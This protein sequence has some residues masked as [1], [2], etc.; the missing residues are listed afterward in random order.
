LVLKDAMTKRW[1]IR[2]HDQSLIATLQSQ[3]RVSAVVA[4]MLAAR[5]LHSP[6]QIQV[7]LNPKLNDLREPDQLPGAAEAAERLIQAVRARRPI[8][9][10]GDYD[11]DGITG[12][13]LLYE[14]LSLAGAQ[15][16]YYVPHRIDEGYGLHDEALETL[17]ARGASLVVTVDCGIGSVAQAETARR[18]GLELIITDHHTPGARLPAAAAIVHPSLP[19]TAYPFAGLS[20]AGV[21]FKLAWAVCQRAAE[22]KKVSPPMRAFLI[23]A[24][25][26]AAIGT[27]ADVVPLLDENRIIVC[28]GLK[29]LTVEPG[30]G[31]G[32]LMKLTKLDAKRNL[33]AEDIGFTL[34]PRLNAAGRLGQAQLA[35][36]LLTTSSPERATALAEYLHELNSSRE[37]LERSVHLASNKQAQEMFDPAGDAALVLAG[38]DWH[39]GVIGIVAGRLAEKYHRPVVLISLDALGVKPGIGSVRGVAGFDVQQALARC[40]ELLVSHGGH[41]AAAGLKIEESQIEL[42]RE[43][44]CRHA[45]D[46]STDGGRL[47]DL[48]IDAEAPLSAL[49]LQAIEQLEQLGPFGHGNLRPLLCGM[50]LK[51]VAPPRKIGGGGRHLSLRLAQHGAQIRGVA[52]GM[53]DQAEELERAG[54]SLNVAFRPVVNR[55]QGR[56]AVELHV[57]DWQPASAATDR[58]EA[59]MTVIAGAQAKTVSDAG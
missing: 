52:F 55:F 24:L 30:L 29:S 37:S 20:G 19:G 11:A 45:E 42:F 57:V 27:V 28:H 18:L 4:Q 7:F 40:S 46:S 16:S 51:L 56:A 2:P 8:V 50:G 5:G 23:K 22:A 36:E 25:G 35:V 12:T 6:A 21:A 58:P 34:G 41:A 47:S 26:L 15:V 3:S 44:F 49:T 38:R 31:L 43:Q 32:C 54:G 33:E 17:A 48:W 59:C 10:Y 39:A 13:A 14:C 1:R 9:V 53:G